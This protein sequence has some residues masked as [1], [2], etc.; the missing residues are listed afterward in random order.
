MFT[1]YLRLLSFHSETQSSSNGVN[2]PPLKRSHD[3]DNSASSINFA[4]NVDHFYNNLYSLQQE[5]ILTDTIIIYD[6]DSFHCHSF[7]ISTF[8]SYLKQKLLQSS[9]S[10]IE[11]A[12]CCLLSDSDLVFSVLKT[13]YG[14]C[15]HV[16]AQSLPQLSAVASLLDFQELSEFVTERMTHGLKNFDDSSFVLDLNVVASRCISS[17]FH[18]VRVSYK[19]TPVKTNSVILAV[20]SR[21]FYTSFICDFADKETRN[22]HYS[23]EFPGVSENIFRLFFE[24]FH[25]KSIKLNISNVLDYFQLS[26][27]FQVDELK[28]A[29]NQFL[30][31]NC[32]SETELMC[33]LQISN[34]RD[35][36]NFVEYNIEIFKILS[37]I[38]EEPFPLTSSFVVLL[39]P[40]IDIVWLFRCLMELH[41]VDPFSPSE[42]S[43]LLSLS[44]ISES[45]CSQIFEILKPLFHLSQFTSIL[46]E[47]SIKTFQTVENS[48]TITILWFFTILCEVDKKICFGKHLNFL[49]DIFTSVIS[50]CCLNDHS[51][52]CFS[53]TCLEHLCSKLPS[54]YCLWLARSLLNSWKSVKYSNCPLSVDVF[55]KCVQSITVNDS[56]LLD[57]L[58][59]LMEL[60]SDET[61]G[62]FINSYVAKCSHSYWESRNN[63]LKLSNQLYSNGL[64]FLTS[65]CLNKNY[66]AA[67]A[68]FQESANMN[69]V[70]A[71]FK[72]GNCYY[73]GLGVAKNLNLAAEYFKNAAELGHVFGMVNVGYCYYWGEGLLENKKEAFDWFKKAADLNNSEAMYWLSF[74]YRHHSGLTQNRSKG[75]R[76]LK[77]SAK[78]GNARAMNALISRGFIYFNGNGVKANVDEAIHHYQ[79]ASDA[80]CSSAMKN[81][82]VKYLRGIVVKKD[83]H[84]AFE[85]FEKSAKLNNVNGIDQ[86]ITC[87]KNG[88]GTDCDLE[89]AMH[90]EAKKEE[91]KDCQAT[92]QL[93]RRGLLM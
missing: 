74:S 92:D 79:M 9:T 40:F 90:W 72:L 93:L 47:W 16:T 32:F 57:Y 84:T 78:F 4:F 43:E 18:D 14:Q 73:L 48:E 68:L 58:K 3:T 33:L 69:N 83:L 26:S 86:L 85:L 82:G 88:V 61:L 12:N 51:N 30:T 52:Y 25:C 19:N 35:Q 23:G 53:F 89:K 20:F 76:W 17:C 27:Y 34:E 36:L 41:K 5:N 8:S 45:E 77:L 6:G 65:E 37:N 62:V 54:E 29:C 28:L 63:D 87:I 2:P 66:S 46:I 60:N 91:L 42:L 71:I 59:L 44:V 55:A 81:L 56:N 39:L 38:D 49:S 80:G 67:F 13:F 22:F 10:T 7:I 15:L 11:L 75:I 31:N 21:T 24:L 70:E 50:P 64:H 1:K